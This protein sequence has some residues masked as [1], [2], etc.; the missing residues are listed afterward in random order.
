MEPAMAQPVD[1]RNITTEATDQIAAAIALANPNLDAAQLEAAVVAALAAAS[2]IDVNVVGAS[3][4]PFATQT[5]TVP[6]P[7]AVTQLNALA[8]PN[9]A[10]IRADEDMFVY[11]NAVPAATEGFLVYEGDDIRMTTVT[12]LDQVFVMPAKNTSIEVW[13][14]T[15]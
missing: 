1:V 4:A 7:P 15:L 11:A 2:P 5:Q 10:L 6:V 3:S 9:G 14:V 13:A 8:T 12:N